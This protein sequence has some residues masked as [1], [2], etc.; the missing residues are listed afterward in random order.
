MK[1]FEFEKLFSNFPR[2]HIYK[3]RDDESLTVA[4]L[5]DFMMKDPV[6]ITDPLERWK[7]MI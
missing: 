3:S 1:T 7:M 6:A 5:M 4:F 2:V